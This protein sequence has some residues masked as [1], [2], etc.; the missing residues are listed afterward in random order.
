VVSLD[1]KRAAERVLL[2]AVR[3][4]ELSEGEYHHAIGL[5]R[6]AVTPRDLWKATGGRAGS[7]KR[8]DRAELG[9]AIRLQVA[10]VIFAILGMLLVL[11]GTILWN[12]QGSL[13]G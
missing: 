9:R 3:T 4:G 2:D 1:D 13:G 7:P 11:W 6:R 5:V 12:R 10:V 8:A